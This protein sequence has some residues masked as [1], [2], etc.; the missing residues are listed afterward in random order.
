VYY[1]TERLTSRQPYV[2]VVF[3][4][5]FYDLCVLEWICSYGG[6]ISTPEKMSASVIH[7]TVLGLVMIGVY[8]TLS[9]L[10]G[11]YSEYILK[12]KYEVSETFKH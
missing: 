6:L 3:G 5:F 7:I 4:I 1:S 9:G 11:V 2:G 10:A 8:T 12:G